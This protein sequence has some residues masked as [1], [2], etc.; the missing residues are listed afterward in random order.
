MKYMSG[1][2]KFKKVV[3]LG[4][5]NIDNLV[6][7]SVKLSFVHIKLDKNFKKNEIMKHNSKIS[8]N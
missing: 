1:H 5:G 4:A 2:A 3:A 7:C 6:I 8:V